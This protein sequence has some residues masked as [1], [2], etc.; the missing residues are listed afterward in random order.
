MPFSFINI[1]KEDRL[2][3]ITLSRSEKKNALNDV[4]VNELRHAFEEAG[5]DAGTKIIILKAAGDV[6]SAGADLDYLQRLQNFSFEE[7]LADS[8]N[9]K[10]LFVKITTLGKIVIAQVEGHAIAGGC[11]LASVCDF[12]FAVPESK[13]GYTEVKIGF[14]PALVMVFL[15]RKIGGTNARELMLTGKLITA[16][17]AK[18]IGLINEVVEKEKISTHVKLFAQ[19]LAKETSP[20]SVATIKEMINKVSSMEITDALNYAARMNANARA[21]T[22]CKKGIGAF[23]KKETVRW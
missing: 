15:L 3:Y 19:N 21:S 7:N 18:Q 9:L 12:C 16:Q 4:L 1:Q 17:E 8:T 11:G 14:I 20:Q 10:E 5:N 13:F 23:L 2:A 22:D 6:F